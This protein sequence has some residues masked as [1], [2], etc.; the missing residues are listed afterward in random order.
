[1]NAARI[2]GWRCC[3]FMRFEIICF[4]GLQCRDGMQIP[5]LARFRGTRKLPS[6][7]R[8]EV[9]HRVCPAGE[10]QINI[11]FPRTACR[12][13]RSDSGIGASHGRG[14]L[15][16]AFALGATKLAAERKIQSNTN[17]PAARVNHGFN[18]TEYQAVDSHQAEG[19]IK[20]PRSARRTRFEPA[21]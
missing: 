18:Q 14:G 12:L 20:Q 4:G 6:F 16:R 21:S 17:S 2:L 1:M 15:G 3:Q 8:V 7:I 13:G 11:G 10:R 19:E 5:E 9:D